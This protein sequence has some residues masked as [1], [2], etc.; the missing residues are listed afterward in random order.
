[1]LLAG[2]ATISGALGLSLLALLLDPGQAAL[3]RDG[4]TRPDGTA[5]E[6]IRH[7]SVVAFG[8]VFQTTRDVTI[9]GQD[10]AAGEYVLCSLPS[11]DRDKELA[12]GL[13]RLDVTREPPHH[14]A[15]GHGAHH[16]LG[17]EL[18]R[19][20]PRVCVPRVLRRL[21]GL[22]LRVPLADL[23]FTPLNAAY[24]VGYLPADW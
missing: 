21:P 24:G 12:D 14:L 3:V 6:L 16:C 2:Y 19:M 1:M 9:A 18:A 7:L 8:K 22:R 5:E 17:A 13:D 15:L 20:E 4:R 23:R 11:A 10:I